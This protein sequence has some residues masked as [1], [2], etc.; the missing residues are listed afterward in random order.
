MN[1]KDR[2]P[3]Y[4]NACDEMGIE[5]LPPDV[6]SSQLR[7]RGRR[8]ED[9]LRAER[10]QERRRVGR[11]ARSS[12]AREEGGPFAS[13]WDFTERVDPQVV[14]KRALESLVKCG[15]LD[16]TG[17]SRMGMLAVLE[18]ALAHGQT[19]RGRPARRPGLDLRRR[20]RRGRGGR[21]GHHPPIPTDEFEKQRAAA[22]REGDARPLRLRASARARS[23]TSCGARPTR[24]SPSS[25]AAATARS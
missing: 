14:N 25:S 18:Q 16:S 2:V 21:R 20:L 6:N 7:L 24:R 15:A 8:G 1:T 23:A 4:V 5:V 13:I 10:G 12:R 17:A 3:F 11:A 19:R 9:P 22:A